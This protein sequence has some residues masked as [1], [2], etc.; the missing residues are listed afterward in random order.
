MPVI[1]VDGLTKRFG[2]KV[3]VDT[4]SFEVEEG[5]I[6]VIVGASGC[7]K[8]TTLRAIAGLDLSLIHI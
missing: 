4:L 1:E 5:E 6:L 8:T 7:G 2:E 3:A